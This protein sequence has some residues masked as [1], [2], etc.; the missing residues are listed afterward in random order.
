[1]RRGE[2]REAA[3]KE[4]E[5]QLRREEQLQSAKSWTDWADA[6]IA[7]A[8]V[9]NNREYDHVIR[10]VVGDFVGKIRQEIYD[11]IA[12]VYDKLIDADSKVREEFRVG[13]SRVPI[14]RTWN[15]DE[16]SY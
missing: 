10:E 11:Y 13:M 1:M 3:R 12:R 9:E 2:R 6:K 14:A 15:P 8:V 5:A 16:I 7:N 4:R